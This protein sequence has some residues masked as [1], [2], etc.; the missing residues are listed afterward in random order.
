MM[1]R[2]VM[3]PLRADGRTER[4]RPSGERIHQHA[5]RLIKPNDRLSSFERLEIYNRQYWFRVLSSLIEDFPGLSAVLGARRFEAMCRA[6][7]CDHPSQSFTLRNLGNRLEGWLRRHPRWAGA[8]QALALDM[9]HLEWAQIE[10]FDGKA[11]PVLALEDL[12]GANSRHLRLKLQPYVRLLSVR[13]PVDELLLRLKKEMEQSHRASQAFSESSRRRCLHIVSK[14]RAARRYLAIHRIHFSVYI[15]LLEPE[16][17]LALSALS[18]GKTI[19]RAVC[20]AFDRSSMVPVRRIAAVHRWF[21]NWAAL[22]WLVALE[23]S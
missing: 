9:V 18:T 2:S 3:L 22:G 14:R 19:G 11:W 7:L 1:A 17:F 23:R 16:E 21:S 4:R 13:H 5:A 15:R 8:K 10:A 20:L 12:G 6:Y